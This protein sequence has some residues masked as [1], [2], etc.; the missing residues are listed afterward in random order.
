M[1][2]Y[3]NQV[4]SAGAPLL[5]AFPVDGANSFKPSGKPGDPIDN[6]PGFVSKT[7]EEQREWD[8]GL[9]E[10]GS[11]YLE[12]SKREGQYWDRVR[13]LKSLSPRARKR[14]LAREA[15]AKQKH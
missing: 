4:R 3:R 13:Y 8:E 10:A 11:T 9:R 6:R 14:A 12:R 7:R 2:A 1:S 15:K 5:Y